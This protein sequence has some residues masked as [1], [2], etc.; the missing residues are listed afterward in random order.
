LTPNTVFRFPFS[1]PF[2]VLLFGKTCS[3]LVLK[4]IEVA[5]ETG[6]T[7]VVVVEVVVGCDGKISTKLSGNHP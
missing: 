1:L 3:E 2:C 7:A 6:V 5:E 4:G